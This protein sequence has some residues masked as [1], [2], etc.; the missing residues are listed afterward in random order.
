MSFHLI[1]QSIIDQSSNR[2][3][4]DV[5]EK[6]LSSSSITSEQFLGLILYYDSNTGREDA[7]RIMLKYCTV[8]ES[9]MPEIIL[10][11]DS[12][13]GRN[14]ILNIYGGI[15]D[16]NVFTECFLYY[17]SDT[18]RN[19]ALKYFNGTLD[20]DDMD[21]LLMY[22]NSDTG[23]SKAMEILLP[24]LIKSGEK[25]ETVENKSD[26]SNNT[27]ILFPGVYV[28]GEDKITIKGTSF[29]IGVGEQVIFKGIKVR[30]IE[31]S[32]YSCC[33]V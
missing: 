29:T 16:I 10:Y 17:D 28:E 11:M 1:E 19:D 9:D 4:N 27:F 26:I 24:K 8:N 31:Q 14:N 23:R 3:R 32:K 12:N 30:R 6:Y 7:L 2:G 15:K 25:K 18:G 20:E 21:K 5:L 22:Y 33:M 13:T